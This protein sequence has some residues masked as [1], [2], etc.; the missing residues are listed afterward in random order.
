MKLAP[1]QILQANL[2]SVA[3][4]WHK[5]RLSWLG[6]TKVWEKAKLAKLGPVK[7]TSIVE[8]WQRVRM[9]NLGMPSLAFLCVAGLVVS[10]TLMLLGQRGDNSLKEQGRQVF[11]SSGCSNCH[12]VIGSGVAGSAKRPLGT[13]PDLA[14]TP[15]RTDDWYQAY[16][17]KPQAILPR[18]PMPSF[19]NLGDQSTKAVI[20]YIQS[21]KPKQSPATPQPVNPGDI[22]QVSNDFASYRT[23]KQLFQTYCQGCHGL[24]GNGAGPV[25]Q[26][27][28]P[29]PRDFTDVAWMSRQTD[30]YLFSVISD[31][32]GNTAMSG[33]K[34]LLSPEERALLLHYIRYFSDP[35]ARQR[36]EQALPAE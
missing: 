24:L 28:S 16:L 11:V 23:G 15:Y 9:A 35:I 4:M 22:S 20:A 12:T 6:L 26:V 8:T 13:P 30:A 31:G 14:T 18:S 5:M 1:K 34:D 32:K 27:L 17:L 3:A 36:M 29:E 10:L 2:K 7:V 25:G 21:L 19:T 33:L